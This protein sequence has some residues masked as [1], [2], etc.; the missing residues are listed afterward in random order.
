MSVVAFGCMRF[1]L[2]FGSPLPLY[3][4]KGEENEV[5]YPGILISYVSVMIMIAILAAYKFTAYVRV[6]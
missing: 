4:M 2:P 6:Y 1:I 3:F 5:Y